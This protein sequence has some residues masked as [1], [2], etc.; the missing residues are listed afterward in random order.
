MGHLGD[1]ISA[2]CAHVTGDHAA[3]DCR[4]D[5]TT[6]IRLLYQSH[7][8]QATSGWLQAERKR[9]RQP[10]Q[11]ATKHFDR[12]DFSCRVVKSGITLDH[13]IVTALNASKA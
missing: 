1:S 11:R 6:P 4:P 12:H 9:L 13:T 2:R 7:C 3:A 8:R 5:S 10:C